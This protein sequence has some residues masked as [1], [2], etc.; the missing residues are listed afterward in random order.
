MIPDS[1][2]LAVRLTLKFVGAISPRWAAALAVRL[3]T[4]PVGARNV[5]L[6]GKRR[7][8]AE[9]ELARARSADLDGLA[10]WIWEDGSEDLTVILI[11]GWASRALYMTGFVPP[12]RKA[13]FRV[14]ALDFPGHGESDGNRLTFH[15]AG[16]AVV[17]LADRFGPCVLVGHS[18]GA[19]MCVLA[20][21]GAPT[22]KPSESVAGLV[23]V[24]GANRLEDVTQRF[25]DE[26][27]IS[28]RVKSLIDAKLEKLGG[29]RIERFTS[30]NGIR[31]AGVPVLLLHDE[32]DAVVPVADARTIARET[33]A[34]LVETRHLGH[35]RILWAES[36]HAEIA[37]FINEEVTASAV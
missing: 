13:G 4:T 17:D 15:R 34:T 2:R 3:F 21:A 35:N 19:S 26:F 16:R 6:K 20:A 29:D 11:H 18:F 32:G 14:V 31:D 30:V 5:V 24:A 22:L 8:R 37:R 12:L 27:D 10:A 36:T 1:V 28:S 23:L 25:A 9:A 33:D 7:E